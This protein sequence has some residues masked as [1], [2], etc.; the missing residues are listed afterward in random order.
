MLVQD[1]DG[2]RHDIVVGGPF[3]LET[4]WM[5]RHTCSLGNVPGINNPQPSGNIMPQSNDMT[6]GWMRCSYISGRNALLS[7]IRAYG[8]RSVYLPTYCCGSIVNAIQE[9]VNVRYY[10][11]NPS[12]LK[13]APANYGSPFMIAPDVPE[14]LNKKS[15]LVYIDYFGFEFPVETMKRFRA[16][17]GMVLRDLSHT[18]YREPEFCDF[19]LYSLRKTFGVPDGAHLVGPEALMND[20]LHREQV[21]GLRKRPPGLLEQF[22]MAMCGLNGLRGSMVDNTWELS[23]RMLGNEEF[24]QR[25]ITCSE[26]TD[27][28]MHFTHADRFHDIKERRR[29]NY[30][31]LRQ[32]FSKFCLT[33]SIGRDPDTVPIGFPMFVE[34][35]KEFLKYLYERKIYPIQHWCDVHKDDQV[36]ASKQITLPCDQRYSEQDMLVLASHVSGA[37]AASKQHA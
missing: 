23:E 17:G 11:C 16:C 24:L 3:P 31:I 26:I 33:A 36:M 30:S 8:F 22:S 7:L 28:V 21:P 37:I 19:A 13:S 18:I 6:K 12:H 25:P 9:K 34:N 15:L 14:G 20:L 4:S 29:Q 27:G 35:K 5:G 1:G 2:V 32:R 10:R